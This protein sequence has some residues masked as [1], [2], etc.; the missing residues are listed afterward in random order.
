[1][2]ENSV[3]FNLVDISEI[4]G[5][6]LYDHDF[7]QYPDRDVKEYKLARRSK[8]IITSAEYIDKKA[9]VWLHIKNCDRFDAEAILVTLKSY[10]QQKNKE[11]IINQANEVISYIATL[12]SIDHS[13]VGNNIK[14]TLNFI[15]ADPLG[16]NTVQTNFI[17]IEITESNI[18]I[19]VNIEGSARAEPYFTINITTVTGGSNQTISIYNAVLNQ[20]ISVSG[21]WT[22]GD[23]LEI[24]CENERVIVNGAYVD[25][26]GI[27]PFF[28]LGNQSV[29]YIDTFSTRDVNLIGTYYKRYS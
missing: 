24:D 11:L 28:N 15:C 6:I 27:F 8:S 23:V 7:N 9:T 18:L 17:N 22:N 14:I 16:K 20:G 21:D 25:F 1:M 19:P 5:T 29:Q 3:I 26:S 2:Q 4:A 13:W 12:K 10:I